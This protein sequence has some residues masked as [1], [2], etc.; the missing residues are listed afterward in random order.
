VPLLAS[1]GK[2]TLGTYVDWARAGLLMAYAADIQDSYR[3]GGVYVAKILQGAT[4]ADLPIEQASKFTLAVNAKTA[5]RLGITIPLS[6]LTLADEV[7]E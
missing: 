5:K 7:I 4:P 6:L 2:P 1:S 3:R